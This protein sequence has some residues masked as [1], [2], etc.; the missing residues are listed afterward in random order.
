MFTI[1]NCPVCD[2]EITGIIDLDSD[3]AIV[4]FIT[5]RI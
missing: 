1:S 5:D 2:G 4:L 3:N